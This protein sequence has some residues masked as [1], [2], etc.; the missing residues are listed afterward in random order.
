MFHYLLLLASLV[1]GAGFSYL[2]G[3]YFR[4][5]YRLRRQGQL[6][7]GRILRS[8]ARA[9][10]RGGAYFTTVG[11]T[12]ASGE[13]LAV[14]LPLGLPLRAFQVGEPIT[15]YYDPAQP[16][17]C[18]V[19]SWAERGSYLGLALIGWLVTS[20]MLGDVLTHR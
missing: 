13:V 8:Q 10:G 7:Q 20:L 6:A 2:A 3:S 14:E 17:R 4:R 5:W 1:P 11:F 9:T 15:V 12:A 18:V 19:N 16:R